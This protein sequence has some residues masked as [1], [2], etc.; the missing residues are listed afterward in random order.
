M[1]FS[2]RIYCRRRSKFRGIFNWI[3]VLVL[4]FMFACQEQIFQCLFSKKPFK[5]LAQNS[6]LKNDFLETSVFRR[7]VFEH[8]LNSSSEDGAQNRESENQNFVLGSKYPTT[9]AGIYQHKGY[10]TKCEYL[11]S[12]PKCNAGGFLG[13]LKFFYCDCEK[14]KALGYVVLVIWLLVLFY[15]LGNTAAEYFCCSLEILSNLLRLPPTVSGVTLLPLGNGAPDVFASIASFVGRDSGDLGLNSVLG[16]AVFVTCVVL[17]AVSFSI[18]GQTV[19]IDKK[20]FFRDVGF[21]IFTLLSLLCILLVGKVSVGGAIAFV[22]IYLVYGLCVAAKE[23]LTKYGERLKLGSVAPLLPVNGSASSCEN[24]KDE[25]VYTSPVKHDSDESVPHLESHIPHCVW[26]S[27]EATSNYEKLWGWNDEDSGNHD[28]SL[29]SCSKL[30]S[31]LE[32]PLVLPRRLTIPIVEEERWSKFYAVASAFFAPVVLAVLWNTQDH[33]GHLAK[34]IIYVVGFV[35][36]SILGVLALSYTKTE[37]PPRKF[38]LPWVLGGFFMSVIWFYVIANELVALLVA[39]GVI[40]GIKS[41]LLALTILAWG[42]SLGDLMA[43]VAIAM[44][45]G[46]GVQVA[47]SGCFAGPMFNTLVGLGIS[48][49]IAAWSKKSSVYIIPRDVTLYYTIGFLVLGLVWSL[50]MFSR[51]GMRPGKLLGAGLMII[52]L[53]FLTLRASI[54]ISNGMLNGSS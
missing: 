23:I 44:N 34:G 49:V 21:F 9:C 38:L 16:A 37:H 31:L 51:N 5:N 12:N 40:L 7:K 22:S 33:L 35:V 42:N 19:R 48:L 47:I 53:S 36:G 11:R 29:F 10:N 39:F 26:P 46:D 14:F 6:R 20:C 15:F 27:N 50:V 3:C 8:S 28:Q 43:N 24:G 1:E 45:G 54:A 13:Y 30:W 17:G 32:F 18:S 41:S 25:S 4:L 2:S 52:Y